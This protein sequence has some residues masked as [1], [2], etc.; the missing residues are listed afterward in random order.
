ML[1]DPLAQTI[2][3]YDQFSTQY[4]DRWFKSEV[5]RDFFKRFLSLLDET[6]VVLDAGCGSGREVKE[7]S[8]RRIDCVGIDLSYETVKQARLNVPSGYFRVMDVRNLEYPDNIFDGLLCV[9]VLHHLFERDFK[10]AILEFQ[11][12]TKPGGVIA[13]TIRMGDGF[14]TDGLGRLVVLRNKDAIENLISSLGF[15][16]LDSKLSL[17]NQ[18]RL[19][20]QLIILNPGQDEIVSEPLCSFCKGSQFLRENRIAGAPVAASVLWGDEQ[21]LVTLDVAPVV[22]GHLLLVTNKHTLSTL[23]TSQ[24]LARISSHKTQI[25]YILKRA[26]NRKPIFLEHGSLR[27]SR[28]PCIEHAHIH[29]MPLRGGLR[30]RLQRRIGRLSRFQNL[31]RA[32]EAVEGSEYIAY[33]DKR[34]QIFLKN[35]NVGE[36]PS[37]FM[38]E[39]VVAALG[40]DEYRWIPCRDETSTRDR[41]NNTLKSVIDILDAEVLSREI[42]SDIPQE[43]RYKL[44]R[45]DRHPA[46]GVELSKTARGIASKLTAIYPG[47]PFHELTLDNL[48][49]HEIVQKILVPYFD[50]G[51]RGASYI[52]DDAAVFP[53]NGN[54]LLATSDHCPRPLFFQLGIESYEAYGWLSVV[55]SLSDIA[56]MGGEPRAVLLNTEMPPEMRVVDYLSFVEGVSF[57]A[58]MYGARV[59]G[60]NI[61]EASQFAASTTVLGEVGRGG[62]LRRDGAEPGHALFIAGE[63]GLFW[64]GVFQR[65]HNLL[66]PL[67]CHNQLEAGLLFPEPKLAVAQLLTATGV[68]GAC[69]DASD[70]PTQAIHSLARASSCN[71]IV[72]IDSL[73]PSQ[74]VAL[75]AKYLKM[76]PVALMFTW[77]NFDLV[78]TAQES[79]LYRSIGSDL[80]LYK[81][82]KVGYVRSGPGH[83]FALSAGNKVALPHLSVDQFSGLRKPSISDYEDV[84]RK[85]RFR[86]SE[87]A[88]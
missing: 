83:A 30:T 72:D 34:G 73:E 7:L 56:A 54:R 14:M 57:A 84:L 24:D 52:G 35:K 74:A 20:L 87:I 69:M 18:D 38:R 60:G 58:N 80:G 62:E 65:Y 68:T 40:G 29:A 21:F 48:G 86:I 77:G 79:E 67:E 8:D 19:W 17:G 61:R 75:A 33:E 23:G 32:D 47:V 82:R 78:F 27:Q 85:A 11:R 31:A 41:Y 1:F 55:I 9:A 5:I 81:I 26:F 64:A 4:S 37:Q 76:D 39:I 51:Y 46:R 3:A 2:A 25:D 28:D 10:K 71:I 70:G 45:I 44:G 66:L 6:A 43:I 50:S 36:L 88:T 22:E 13:L 12:V 53:W 63:M 42:V 15:S 16:V 49:E 59:I